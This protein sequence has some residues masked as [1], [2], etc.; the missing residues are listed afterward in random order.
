MQSYGGDIVIYQTT[1]GMQQIFIAVPYGKTGVSSI[2]N[3][4][5]GSP[6]EVKSKTVYVKGANN[7]VVD[8]A[9]TGNYTTGMKYTLYYVDNPGADSGTNTYTI[10]W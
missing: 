4:V 9:T 3:S 6:L 8:D 10:N 5:N 7:Y 2:K 1:T